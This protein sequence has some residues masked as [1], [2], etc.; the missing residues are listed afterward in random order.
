MRRAVPLLPRYVIMAVDRDSLPL[1]LPFLFHTY[2][3]VVISDV[4]RCPVWWTANNCTSQRIS[5][6][7]VVILRLVRVLKGGVRVELR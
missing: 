6:R 1:P 2:N 7:R 3:C 4:T 5:F